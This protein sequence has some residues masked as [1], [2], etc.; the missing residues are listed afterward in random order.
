MAP[1]ISVITPVYNGVSHIAGCLESVIRQS[2]VQAEHVLI[3]GG[4]TDGTIDLISQYTR[5][6]AH[7]RCVSGRDAGQADAM[8]KGIALA[9]GAVLGFLNVDDRYEPGVLNHILDI[10]SN[11]QEPAL[12]VGDCN[13]WDEN[14]NLLG[15]N[16]PGKLDF[17]SLLRGHALNPFPINP[18]AYFYHK[19]LHELIGGYNVA[20]SYVLDWD[21]LLR[22][23]Q[24]ADVHYYS[25]TWGNY[26][27]L[28]GTKTYADMVSGKNRE[29]AERL[30]AAYRSQLPR[31]QAAWLGVES[32]VF[33]SAFAGTLRY[34][35]RHPQELPWRAKKRLLHSLHLD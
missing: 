11:L 6:F 32:R 25:E 30:L 34:F 17:H 28:P 10:F 3:D 21:F 8:N 22:A 15:V 29:R 19:S 35:F 2:C 31:R 20:E 4:S 33:G 23:V 7:I 24:A 9:H 16:V 18:S 27:L 1:E 12:V 5:R 13:V 14:G 26:F